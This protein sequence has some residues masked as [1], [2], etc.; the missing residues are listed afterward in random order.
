LAADQLRDETQRLAEQIA[1]HSSAALESG[2]RLLQS[3]ERDALAARYALASANMAADL[4]MNDAKLGID[5]FLQK[6][7]TPLWTHR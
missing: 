1:A 4:Q 5:A 6:A 7:P 3:F 2:K